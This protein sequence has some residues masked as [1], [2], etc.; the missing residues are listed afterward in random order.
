MGRRR[1][2]AAPLAHWEPLSRN[3][4]SRAFPATALVLPFWGQTFDI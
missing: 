2:G 4:G 1:T 3:L